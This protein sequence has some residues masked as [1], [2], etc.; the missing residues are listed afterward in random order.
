[1]KFVIYPPAGSSSPRRFLRSVSQL[2]PCPSTPSKLCESQDVETIMQRPYRHH[3]RLATWRKSQ[4]ARSC[5]VEITKM[6]PLCFTSGRHPRTADR[7]PKD[8]E[9]GRKRDARAPFW[10][11]PVGDRSP[12]GELP[13]HHLQLLVYRLIVV[14]CNLR[15]ASGYDTT[16]LLIFSRRESSSESQPIPPP[17]RSAPRA[18]SL[19]VQRASFPVDP[20]PTPDRIQVAILE[21]GV[22]SARA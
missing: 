3:Q 6:F 1:M 9:N 22:H 19:G 12:Y 8:P 5:D 20:D 18:G 15:F 10:N 17:S 4:V 16:I 13:H 21:R 14:V 7:V 2:P 11:V